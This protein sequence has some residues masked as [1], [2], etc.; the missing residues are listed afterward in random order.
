MRAISTFTA[1]CGAV[2][3]A[4]CSSGYGPAAPTDPAPRPEA[5]RAPAD[6]GVSSG[7]KFVSFVP[8]TDP[9]QAPALVTFNNRTPRTMTLWL[10][11]MTFFAVAPGET[12]GPEAGPSANVRTN[13]VVGVHQ[14]DTGQCVRYPIGEYEGPAAF[15]PAASY[16]LDLTYIDQKR[17]FR[18][19]LTDIQPAE[20]FV[21]VRAEVHDP[22]VRWDT[23]SILRVEIGDQAEPLEFMTGE[24]ARSTYAFSRGTTRAVRAVTFVD[25]VGARFVSSDALT[26]G[27]GPGFT[28][29]VDDKPVEGAA[30]LRLLPV[31]P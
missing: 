4:A 29:V 21:A 24:D 25:A 10:S 26:L 1:I 23:L 16:S 22:K 2:L 6:G 9:S 27:A 5:V 11:Q 19:V 7:P 14:E 20:P 31:T 28:A 17:G 30:S 13:T 15:V 8:E 18:A 12:M 3:L